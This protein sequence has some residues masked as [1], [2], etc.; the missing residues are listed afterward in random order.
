[1][2]AVLKTVVPLPV[3]QIVINEI[4]YDPAVTNAQF[5]EFYN[6][7]TNTEFN[8]SGWQ[9]SP[10]SYVFPPG[11]T[12][13]PNSFL[14]LAANE[15][16]YA[17][18]Y[19]ATH[20][21]FDVFSGALPTNG[22]TMISL[23]EPQN[24][25][26]LTVAQ[27]EYSSQ[28]PWP[29]NVS[30]TGASL[31]LID[32]RQDNWRAGN[33]SFTVSNATPTLSNS[34][35]QRLPA[36]PTLW[37]NEVDPDNLTGITN[38]A[39]D[40][41]PWIELFNPGSNSVSLTG[42]YLSTN[43]SDLTSWSFPAGATINAGSFFVVFADGQTSL[44]TA[45]QPH[46]SFTLAPVSGS[47][48]LS[49]LYNGTPQALDYLDY[50]Q[51]A[52]NYSYGSYPDGQ[53][54]IRQI[55]ANPTPGGSNDGSVLPPPSFIPYLVA[56]SS[57]T[58][59]FDSLPDPGATSVNTANPVTINGITYSLSNP[60]DFAYPAVAT[61]NDGGL[62][63][64]ALEGWYGL[65]DP[66]A[67]I[68]TRFGATDGDQT[69]GG[70]ISFGLPNS[71]NRALGLLAT[72]TTGY[73]AFGA[74]LINGTGQTLNFITLQV[75]GEVWRQSNLPKTLEFYYLIDPTDTNAFSTTATA[76]LPAL[77]VSFPTV[78][79]DVGG[80]AVDGTAA[81][82]QT[83]LSVVNQAITNWPSGG[84]LWLVWE[85]ADSTG[86]S[87]G[88]GIDNLT[89]SATAQAVLSPVS[90]TVQTS[91][92]NFV[93]TWPGTVGQSYQIQYT[94]NLANPVWTPVSAPSSGSGA[95]VTFTNTPGAASQGFYRLVILPP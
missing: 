9:V 37:L 31:Q 76:F 15:P 95:T 17:G 70:D 57:Y 42:L 41:V 73:T 52:P 78:P 67:S 6:N 32:P 62:G 77:N 89:F 3:G 80:A 94:T 29:T 46:T 13:A 85:M 19:G 75:T 21:P 64:A 50:S 92:T 87:Q 84:A 30:G 16:A 45:A 74:K 40:H 68:G 43:Y 24:G 55:F 35:A 23:L 10:L 53:S 60:V 33:W 14:V 90:V 72:S 59:N 5:V 91:G 4:M 56:G 88:L 66:T 93:L 81:I 61:G 2:Q 54:F 39:G 26:N 82:D 65:A 49:R 20:P 86:K 51:M 8:L 47:L 27:V 79:G 44:S 36:F 11:S 12:I 1:V 28:L 48:A 83:N 69:T 18:A 34:V 63:I 71:S 58:Q 25:T 22:E 7:S 38:S